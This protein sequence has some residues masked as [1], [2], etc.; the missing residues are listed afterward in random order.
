MG[1]YI[2]LKVL[3]DTVDKSNSFNE[4][5]FRVYENKPTHSI[6]R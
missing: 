1:A 6:G 3:W 4:R 2:V 5:V